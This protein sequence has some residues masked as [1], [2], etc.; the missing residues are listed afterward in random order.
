MFEI[1]AT[2]IIQGDM[3]LFTLLDELE[4]RNAQHSG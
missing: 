1:P 2:K 4:D 3:G